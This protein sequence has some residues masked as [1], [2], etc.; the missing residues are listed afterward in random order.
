MTNTP[1]DAVPAEIAAAMDAFVQAKGAAAVAA[2]LA[3]LLDSAFQG[4]PAT[5]GSS[6][7]P[8]KANV[9]ASH[10]CAHST[11]TVAETA[12]FADAPQHEGSA[13]QQILASLWSGMDTGRSLRPVL[14]FNLHPAGKFIAMQRGVATGG[15]PGSAVA[16]A[17]GEASC[18]G[19][20]G[21][22]PGIR[23]CPLRISRPPPAA[24]VGA[25][26]DRPVRSAKLSERAIQNDATATLD[27]VAAAVCSSAA[28]Q[29]VF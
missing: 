21:G 24:A 2:F 20:G 15:A 4:V 14:S 10:D 6:K 17:A 8:A 3:A 1:V 26:S 13:L 25:Q 11:L 23:S 22:S 9:S 18:A 28:S 29:G 12:A 19:F 27:V 7:A 16:G 5:A